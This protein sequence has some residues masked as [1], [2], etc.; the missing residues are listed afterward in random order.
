MTPEKEARECREVEQ[1]AY[2]SECAVHGRSMTECANAR[3]K[4]V[5]ELDNLAQGYYNEAAKGWTKFR[6]AERQNDELREMLLQAVIALETDDCHGKH[7]ECMRC[8][9]IR[10]LREKSN[11]SSG[12]CPKCWGPI[13]AGRELCRQCHDAEGIGTPAERRGSETERLIELERRLNSEVRCDCGTPGCN[14]L[15]DHRRGGSNFGA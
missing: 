7:E 14:K 15:Y 8:Q 12:A 2:H 11:K 6:E 1:L 10:F 5:Q 4:R 9:Q 13:E 3:L